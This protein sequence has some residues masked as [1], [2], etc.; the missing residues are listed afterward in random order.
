MPNGKPKSVDKV[1]D[2]RLLACLREIPVRTAAI[3]IRVG[4]T[5]QRAVDRLRLIPGVK[6][7]KRGRQNLWRLDTQ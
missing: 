5:S 1:S 4:I 6:L 7:V 3:A 2:E